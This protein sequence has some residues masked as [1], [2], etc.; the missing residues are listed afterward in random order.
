MYLWNALVILTEQF[1]HVTWEGF[2]WNNLLPVTLDD[3]VGGGLLVGMVYWFVY[4]RYRKA[5]RMKL[6]LYRLICVARGSIPSVIKIICC[7]DGS[8]G[9]IRQVNIY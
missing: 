9:K 6:S 5:I 2:L 4:I 7:A 3:I 8:D 1:P